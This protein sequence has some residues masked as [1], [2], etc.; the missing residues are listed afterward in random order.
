MR[1]ALVE[2]LEGRFLLSTQADLPLSG[3]SDAISGVIYDDKDS[4]GI[5]DPGET[6]FSGN[7]VY[8]D[9]NHNGQRNKAE[10]TTKTDK[11]GKYRFGGL[12]DTSYPI[13]MESPK[14][15]RRSEKDAAFAIA[16]GSTYTSYFEAGFTDADFGFTNH[17]LIYGTV[18][19]DRDHDGSLSWEDDRAKGSTVYADENGN[20]KFEASEPSATVS[21]NGVFCLST[22]KPGKI[23]LRVKPNAKTLFTKKPGSGVVKLK[24]SSGA[25]FYSSEQ[26]YDVMTIGTFQQTGYI[27]YVGPVLFGLAY[28]EP[29]V[30]ISSV[31]APSNA[32]A[33]IKYTA[34]DPNPGAYISFYYTKDYSTFEYGQLI[35]TVIPGKSGAATLTWDTSAVPDGK[36]YIYA[37]A[38]DD[39]TIGVYSFYYEKKVAIRHKPK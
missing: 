35:A 21:S 17:P 14:G 15:F 10:P 30:T 34:T 23:S 24:S 1:I 6:G 13:L 19:I 36:Y 26:V 37:D 4:D 20:G 32:P 22:A 9:S 3:T 39:Q 11:N 18:Y 31:K 33:T 27:N 16:M 7:R 29:D 8:I 5:R 12:G 25:V 28:P 2:Q 38:G